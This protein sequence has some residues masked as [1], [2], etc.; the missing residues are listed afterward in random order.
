MFIALHGKNGAYSVTNTTE[1]AYYENLLNLAP[2][3]GPYTNGGTDYVLEWSS[4]NRL[5][6]PESRGGSNPAHKG[7]F[8]GLDYMLL[9]NLY[10]MVYKCPDFYFSISNINDFKYVGSTSVCNDWS[11]ITV[12]P[13][14]SGVD[15]RF[16]TSNNIE[17][18]KVN[19]LISRVRQK[20]NTISSVG[21]IKATLVGKTKSI[22]LS[23]KNVW[24]GMPVEQCSFGP[25]TIRLGKSELYS[26]NN[27]VPVN[28]F[29]IDWS[30]DDIISFAG[31]APLGRA[32]FRGNML[33]SGIV[34]LILSNSCG[35][36]ISEIFVNVVGSDVVISPNPTKGY[37]AYEVSLPQQ[38]TLRSNSISIDNTCD[39]K[40]FNYYQQLV[41]SGKSEFPSGQLNL[42]SLRDGI[43]IV[44]L[45]YN[46]IT[47]TSKLTI[48][49]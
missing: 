13:Q 30:G 41:Y 7:Q 20:T 39:I 32:C 14:P 1:Q 19:N 48:K 22:Q 5:V 2:A 18:Q 33:G 35:T 37:V 38:E 44:M 6:W 8:P 40:I 15:V 36:S 12:S 43:Y 10:Q 49:H 29:S 9:Y 47:Y 17:I 24:V 26:I 45:T 25:P 21:W 4:T 28:Y 31:L 42:S 16:E 27:T 34:T 3:E 46:G 23:P 11:E